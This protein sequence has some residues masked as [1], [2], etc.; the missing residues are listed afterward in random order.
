MRAGLAAFA[1][2]ALI[3]AAAYGGGI[4]NGFHFDDGHSIEDNAYLR[5]LRFLPDY[6]TDTRA[7]SPLAQNRSYRPLLLITFALS[8]QLGDGSPRGYHLL[9]LL[10]HALGGGLVGLLARRLLKRAEV[11]EPTATL[12]ALFAAGLFAAHPLGSEAVN[13]LSARSSLLAAVL[14][15]AAVHAYVVAREDR[16]RSFYVWFGVW[17]GLALLTKLIAITVP[18]LCLGWELTFGP[19]KDALSAEGLKVWALRLGVPA[20]VAIGF[21]IFHERMIG[22]LAQGA[23]SHIT[24]GSFFLTE[25]RVWLRFLALFFYPEDL[26]A[27]LT[28]RWST[29]PFDGETFRAIALSAALITLAWRL[30]RRLPL[31]AFGLFWFYATLAPTNSIIPLAEPA[32]EHRVY[33]ALPG[34]ILALLQL[35]PGLFAAWPIFAA[36]LLGLAIYGARARTEI[37]ATERSLW[38][39]VTTCAPD[40]GRA[41]LNLGRALFG[42][43]DRV[44][45]RRAYEKCRS[46]WPNWVYC[47][48]NLTVLELA[49]G[50][51]LAAESNIQEAERLDAN[52]VYAAVWRGEV[53]L[54][55]A[56]WAGAELAFQRALQI[57]P[58]LAQAEE[59]LALAAFF[60]G[61]MEVAKPLLETRRASSGLGWYARGFLL[62][63][64][65]RAAEAEAAYD[66]ALLLLPQHA[67]SRYNRA[68]LYQKSGRRREAIA[69]YQGLIDGGHPSG[70]ALYN[71]VLAL[72]EE[73]LAEEAE[74]RR[75]QLQAQFPD[76]PGLSG[77]TPAP[78]PAP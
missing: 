42:E 15:F 8:H 5:S 4:D 57:A 1:L 51:Q 14:M 50:H 48:L 34:L 74:R 39:S 24:P 56:R 66:Q 76:Y 77:L 25:T 61:R 60:Q 59:G 21:S 55:A 64:G 68:L 22:E 12:A 63:T 16:R 20:V 75:A 71:L 52:N 37:W 29:T 11:E 40:N 32:S 3:T 38:E 46:L 36:G 9:T 35:V 19:S 43:G 67:E 44:G 72:R 73:G 45:A 58:N 18:A 62:D 49:E 13:Y 26:C 10:F 54:A 70:D 31:F 30:R 28:M 27:D 41:Y 53:E 33:V 69:E 47:P 78:G 7:F 23:R 2:S 6:F 65:G 17:F